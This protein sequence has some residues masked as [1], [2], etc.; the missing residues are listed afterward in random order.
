[1]INQSNVQTFT[2]TYLTNNNKI[3]LT[4]VIDHH[5]VTRGFVY[6]PIFII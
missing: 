2:I 1:M 3:E 6:K 5:Q 4:Y